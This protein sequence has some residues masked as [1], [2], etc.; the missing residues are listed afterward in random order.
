MEI[1]AKGTEHVVASSVKAGVRRIVYLSGAGTSPERTEP[2]FRAKVIAERAIERS[3]LEYVILRPSWVYGPDDRS[4]NRFV[5]FVRY[6]PVV[7]IIGDGKNRVQPISVFDVAKVVAVAVFNEEATNRVF[8]LGGPEELT[9]DEIVGRV[10]KVLG[11]HRMLLHQP[12]ALVK[13]ASTALQVLPAP[14]I[15]PEA[16]DFILQESHVDPKPAE[17]T[18]GIAFTPLEEGLRQYLAADTRN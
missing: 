4:L 17:R 7:P 2:W 8:D 16:V 15:S 9:M 12:A 11:T 10:Q 3:G 18:F 6:L 1:D 14:P 5:A 13:V